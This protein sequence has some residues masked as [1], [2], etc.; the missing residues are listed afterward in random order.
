M[1]A[2]SPK[3]YDDVVASV[4]LTITQLDAL[5]REYRKPEPCRPAPNA[6]SYSW[7]VYTAS[8][9]LSIIL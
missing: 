9:T 7:C 5:L 8:T 4:K 6:L 3:K 1:T 2:P